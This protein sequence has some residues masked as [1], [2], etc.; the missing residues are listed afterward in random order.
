MISTVRLTISAYIC[1]LFLAISYTANAQDVNPSAMPGDQKVYS[2]YVAR[3]AADANF[4]EGVYWGDTH[5]HTSYSTDAGMVGATITPEEAFR[6]AKGEEILSNT[7]QRV[8]LIRP[9]DF[10][11]VSDH[12]ENL[13]LAPLIAESNPD[14][15]ANEWGKTVHDLVKAGKGNEAFQ[16]W[17]EDAVT[18]YKDPI[19]NPKM[20]RTV[21]ERETK[22]ADKHNEPGKFSALIGFEW[23]SIST[24]ENPGNLHRVVIFKDDASK[25]NQVLPFSTV[26]SN[27]P[28]KL[29]KYM[30]D[31]EQKTGGSI[32]AIA[33]NGNVSNGQMFPLN[34]LNGK[35]IDKAYA[36]ARRRWEPLYEVTQMKGDGE[37]HPSLSPNDEFA[38][39]GTWDK[40]DISGQK[41]KEDWMLP[42]EYARSALQIGLQQ[43][44]KLGINPYKFGMIGSTDAHT[45]LATTRDENMFGKTAGFEPAPDRFEHVIIRALSGD[46]SLTTYGRELLASGLA[47]VWARENTREGIF[48]AMKKRETFAT[49]GTRIIV[50]LF[51]GWDY[52]ADDVFK[53]DAVSIGYQKGV[54]M[55]GDL[56]P[57]PA[58]KKA[59]VFMVGA[60]KDTWSGNLDRIQI[61]KGWIDNAGELQERIYDVAVSDGRT[62]DADGRARTAV[63]NTV[64]EANATYLNNIGD[65]EL[66]AVWTD[67]DFDPAASAFYYARVLEIPTP[68]WQAYDAKY[69]G[70][71]MPEGTLLS[72]QERAYTSPIWY[73]P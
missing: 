19:D 11:V 51:G 45:G 68:T 8:R 9:L 38:D 57:K 27:D 66:R 31:Y 73:T 70:I 42:F 60:L 43:E 41:P 52:A 24:R 47:A 2:P 32:L 1:G 35:P 63:G 20:T 26:D 29:W 61:V 36:E 10:L 30:E 67:P 64:D 62:I 53:P 39:Y 49:T 69:Y 5:L 28:E 14:L 17:L 21:W 6:F 44:R 46:D 7:G 65:A 37:T 58:D 13:G 22:A 48:N 34:R 15:L 33:H 55:G 16:K 25:A 23:T 50:R 40:G 12:A 54:P 3:K 59:P 71:K 72:H 4:A 56:S 18:V